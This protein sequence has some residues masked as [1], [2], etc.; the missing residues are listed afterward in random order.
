MKLSACC[1]LLL[2]LHVFITGL[3]EDVSLSCYRA[4]HKGL[5]VILPQNTLTVLRHPGWAG[6]AVGRISCS[7]QRFDVQ[8]QIIICLLTEELYRLL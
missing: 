2:Y 8:R 4:D 7:Q 5:G 3:T 6:P 1:K